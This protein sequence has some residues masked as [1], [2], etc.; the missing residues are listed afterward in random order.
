MNTTQFKTTAL[1]A[2]DIQTPWTLLLGDADKAPHSLEKLLAL[3]S[4]PVYAFYRKEGL[5]SADAE[6]LTQ[7][8]LLSFFLVRKSHLNTE[9]TKGRFRDYLLIAARNVLL[10]WRK[11][12][13]AKKRE[14]AKPTL[15]ISELKWDERVW[16]PAGGTTPNEEF[17]RQWARTTWAAAL[18]V[19]RRREPGE[20]TATLELYY[21]GDAKTSQEEAAR[22]LNVSVACLNSRLHRARK[23]LHKILLSMIRATVEN[24]AEAEDEM[25]R[26]REL[27]SR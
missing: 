10:D 14:G 25:G 19:F 6:D 1:Q 26:L 16:E 20:L 7:Q 11:G 5:S 8:L 23:S 15:S 24:E 4:S 3:Y 13:R 17:E 27:L 12:A 2:W 9:P 21:Q 22:K 18:E